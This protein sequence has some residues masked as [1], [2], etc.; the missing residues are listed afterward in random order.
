MDQA[1]LTCSSLKE[2]FLGGSNIG[3]KE[4]EK[5]LCLAELTCLELSDTQISNKSIELCV[6]FEKLEKLYLYGTKITDECVDHIR[7]YKALTILGI[8][9]DTLITKRGIE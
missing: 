1:L 2:L 8:I 5:L 9:E 4:V 3:D 7:R 6:G